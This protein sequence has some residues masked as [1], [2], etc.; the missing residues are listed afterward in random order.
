MDRKPLLIGTGVL[1]A[2]LGLVVL[3][4]VGIGLLAAFSVG[5]S[6]PEDASYHFYCLPEEEPPNET[7]AFRS[8]PPDDRAIIRPAID[9]ET[10]FVNASQAD[11]LA[12]YGVIERNNKTYRCYVGTT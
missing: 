12:Q 3:Y 4:Q 6:Y 7:V 2:V 5:V 11:S 9:G 10:Q 1:L 8:L